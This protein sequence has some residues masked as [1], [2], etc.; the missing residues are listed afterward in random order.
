MNRPRPQRTRL[1]ARYPFSAFA[2]LCVASLA[3][4]AVTAAPAS[5]AT[6]TLTSPTTLSGNSTLASASFSESAVGV[7]VSGNPAITMHWNQAAALG[8][9]FDANL[10]RQ[11]RHLDPTDSYT[12]T[13]PGTMSVD[14]R[15]NNLNVAWDV[16][17]IPLGSPGFTTT[18][19]CNLKAEGGSYHCSLTTGQVPLLDT[20]PIPGPFVRVAL[21]TDVTVTP[22]GL[23]TLREA[24]F[25]GTP[26]GT[27]NLTL[28]DTPITDSFFIPCTV[29]SG[30]E[31]S[32]TLGQLLATPTPGVSIETNLAFEVGVTIPNPFFPIPDPLDP[33]I[34]IPFA[35]P[36]IALGTTT[37]A[38]SMSGDG[39]TFDMGVVQH[40]N[41]PPVVNAGSSPYSGNEGGPISFDGSGSSSVCGFPTLRWDF[42]DGGVAFG[43]HPKHTFADNGVYSG[44][45]TA[46]DAT[47]LTSTTTFSVIV[48]NVVPSVNAGPDTTADWGRP[49]AFNG[50]ATD[51]GLADQ[52]T[53]QYTWDF[54]DG[55]P[56]ASGGP[57]VIHSYSTPSPIAGYLATLNVCDKNLGCNSSS[58]HVIV[59][60]RDTTASYLGDTS[61]TFDTAAMLSASLVDEYGQAANGRMISFQVGADGPFSGLTN[62]SG[63]AAKSYTPT[64]AAGPYTGSSSFAGDAFY[65]SSTSSNSF[66]LALKGTT[67][68]YTGATTGGANKTVVLSAVLKDAT[69]KPLAGKTIN[70]KLGSQL[71]SAATDVSGVASVSLKLA[72]KN[73]TYTVSAT[74]APPVADA[75]YYTGSTQSV[76]FKLQAK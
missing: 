9:Q 60:K 75:P 15:V 64:L 73:G 19:T 30:D 26:D 2:A 16:F 48:D 71:T 66:A 47:G 52:S 14:Y 49:V 62:S 69:G 20:S 1:R 6:T 74:W 36:D 5:A 45:L 54:G 18:G 57:S 11:G 8:T 72:Q 67:T 21:A 10:V 33:V 43:A 4:I 24:T 3:V 27:A 42:S 23:A 13:L 25:S 40:N 39:A 28:G 50:Q 46:T 59:T 29:G 38:I 37:G 12:R 61:G 56:S 17:D 22:Q 76:I 41:I 55:S 68:T 58:R 44:Q 70:F 53:L 65:N 35:S 32:Y 7:T 63:I 51:P 34:Y 31:L